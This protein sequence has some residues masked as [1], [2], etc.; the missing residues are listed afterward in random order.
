MWGITYTHEYR[1]LCE[2]YLS[3]KQSNRFKCNLYYGVSVKHCLFY[4]FFHSEQVST[5]F[6]YGLMCIL[7]FL[8]VSLNTSFYF[9]VHELFVSIA[10]CNV[11]YLTMLFFPNDNKT[12]YFILPMKYGTISVKYI[13]YLYKN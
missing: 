6:S 12:F 11:L 4:T 8:Q 13:S 1:N 5:F 7:H 9:Y 3:V 2:L 10:Y